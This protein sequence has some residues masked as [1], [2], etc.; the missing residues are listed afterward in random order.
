M[1]TLC[2]LICL[3]TF[4][5]MLACDSNTGIRREQ[6]FT[7]AVNMEGSQQRPDP[8][9]ETLVRIYMKRELRKLS[10]VRVVPEGKD[11][12]WRV[13][14]IGWE[15]VNVDGIGTGNIALS[16]VIMSGGPVWKY[17]YHHLQTGPREGLAENC[18]VIVGLIDKLLDKYRRPVSLHKP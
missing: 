16:T 12:D 5:F 1:R 13:S 18:T 8:A 10:D 7:F 15:G 14:L 3:P 9:F 17:E 6:T 4:T 11:A 2:L